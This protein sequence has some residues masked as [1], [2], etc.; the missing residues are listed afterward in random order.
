MWAQ[1]ES[2]HHVK[3]TLNY[4]TVQTDIVMPSRVIQQVLICS[5]CCAVLVHCTESAAAIAHAGYR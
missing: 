3:D 1:A 2:D 5:C 4:V